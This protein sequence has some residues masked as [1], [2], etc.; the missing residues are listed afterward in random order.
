MWGKYKNHFLLH[1]IIFIWGFT[2]ILGRCITLAA[3]PLV[4]YRL[5]IAIFGVL[6]YLLITKSLLKITFNGLLKLFGVGLL[7]A[8]HWIFFYHAIKVSNVSVTLACFSSGTLFV[9]FLEPL[10]F[11]R[12]IIAYEILFGLL[13]F[14]GLYFI[15]RFETKYLLGIF[16]SL[17][18]AFFS[19]L[20]TVFN[21]QLIKTYN[22]KLITFYELL[23]G[24]ILISIYLLFSSSNNSNLFAVSIPDFIYLLIL[25]LVCTTFTFMG[26]VELMKNISPYTMVL[27]VNLEP[28]YGIILAYY[29]FAEDEKMTFG[30]YMGTILILGTIVIDAILKN[31]LRIRKV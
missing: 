8:L 14:L 27:S 25:G 26:S 9:S 11:K 3:V 31:K 30:F 21:G 18:S 13:V 28:V 5:I 1:F 12:K 4:W 15:F 2:A 22:A 10:F 7:I 24:F 6:L 20:F 17:V 23:G 19:S 16:L 29:I